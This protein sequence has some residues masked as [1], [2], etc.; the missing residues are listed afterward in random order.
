MGNTCGC[1]DKS[2]MD[3]EVRVDPVSYYMPYHSPLF[4]VSA[5]TSTFFKLNFVLEKIWR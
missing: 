4:K 2:D 5:L 1:A 3:Q